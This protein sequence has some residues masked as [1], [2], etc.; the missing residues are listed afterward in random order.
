MLPVDR[1]QLVCF[2]N[3]VE[4]GEE[5]AQSLAGSGPD[6]GEP[7]HVSVATSPGPGQVSSTDIGAFAS[8]EIAA[9]HVPAAGDLIEASG[10]GFLD[11]EVDVLSAA[12][13]GSLGQGDQRADGGV[14]AG[15]EEGL[16]IV[17]DMGGRAGRF[18]G[19][20]HVAAHR[21]ADDV[22]GQV[23]AVGSGLAEW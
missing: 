2:A 23:V 10:S 16:V 13:A 11:R 7:D 21:P 6:C 18:A 9:G 4:P 12:G 3:L 8:T 14:A 22:G 19:D 5:S 17:A 20:R 1:L 15:V